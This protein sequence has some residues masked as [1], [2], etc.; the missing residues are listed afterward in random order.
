MGFQLRIR[1]I[2][3]LTV[4]FAAEVQTVSEDADHEI[5]D[6]RH[7]EVPK[8]ELIEL[9]SDHVQAEEEVLVGLVL[10]HD[11]MGLFSLEGRHEGQGGGLVDAT[12]AQHVAVGIASRLSIDL[13]LDF[14]GLGDLAAEKV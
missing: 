11:T 5:E 9:L 14:V 12:K 10:A 6:A 8:V 2:N 13:F 1:V 4:I 3:D 7:A